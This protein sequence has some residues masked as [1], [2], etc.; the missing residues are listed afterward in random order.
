MVAARLK[1]Q[2]I[3]GT[4]GG[5]ECAGL[6]GIF[7]IF[8]YVTSYIAPQDAHHTPTWHLVLFLY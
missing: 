7:F 8:M 1:L 2:F 3:V 6:L 5:L 4:F